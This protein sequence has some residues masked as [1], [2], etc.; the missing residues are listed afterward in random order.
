MNLLTEKNYDANSF[1]GFKKTKSWSFNSLSYMIHDMNAALSADK[2]VVQRTKLS[3]ELIP[4]EKK[5]E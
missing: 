2:N 4:I 5:K 3:R 1:G